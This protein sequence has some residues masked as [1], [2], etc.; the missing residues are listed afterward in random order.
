VQFRQIGTVSLATQGQLLWLWHSKQT[1][2][3]IVGDDRQTFA[4][5]VSGP[6]RVSPL[7]AAKEYENQI[8]P[9]HPCNL[10]VPAELCEEIAAT[11]W[12][13]FRFLDCAACKKFGSG[14]L[15]RTLVFGPDYGHPLIHPASGMVLSFR[16]GAM[17]LFAREGDGFKLIGKTKPKG[18]ATLAYAAHPSESMIAYGDNAGTFHAHRFDQTGFGKAFK[19]AAKERNA[20]RVE[21]AQSGKLLIAGGM[22][23]LAT[24]N[25]DGKKFEPLHDVS[26][27]VRDFVCGDDAKLILVNQGMHGVAAYRDGPEGLTK[28]GALATGSPVNRICVSDCMGYLAVA[29]QDPSV[30]LYSISEG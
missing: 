14:D 27:S 7:N 6:V 21:F 22:G 29:S 4:I 1:A 9:R 28:V 23:Y 11:N 18:K 15:L 3:F 16:K 2:S 12:R 10:P 17:E 24:F 5:P 25:Y 30:S 8:P 20:S 26:T 19:I 13:G